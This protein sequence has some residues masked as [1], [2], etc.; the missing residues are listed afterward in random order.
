MSMDMMGIKKE[1]IIEGVEIAGVAK[2]VSLSQEG[3]NS[4]LI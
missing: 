3:N 1:E 2:Y 4:M